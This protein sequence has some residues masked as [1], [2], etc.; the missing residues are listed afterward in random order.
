MNKKNKY[1]AIIG[2][3]V[4]IA[5]ILIYF[6]GL[7]QE[8]TKVITSWYKTYSPDDEGPYGTYMMKE[9]LDTVGFFGEFIEIDNK[10]TEGL[11]DDPNQ[12]DIYFF[13]G[14]ENYMSDEACNKLLD[15]V[16]DGNTAFISA[17]N[18][19]FLLLDEF[20]ISPYDVYV[21]VN[22]T[23]QKLKF[24]HPNLQSKTYPFNYIYKNK[25]TKHEWI[26]FANNNY[27]V[28]GN[29]PNENHILGQ[30]IDGENNFIHFKY[31]DGEIFFHSTPSI[32]NRFVKRG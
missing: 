2:G 28:W 21:K 8:Q 12:N 14:E 1:I 16:F 7:R 26:Y 11:K 25:S 19:S 15:F 5:I 17:K 30:S 9:L 24:T 22:D 10:L 31:G 27:E 20:F 6:F 32:F 23:L 3:L 18:M 4:F 13:I 29:Q